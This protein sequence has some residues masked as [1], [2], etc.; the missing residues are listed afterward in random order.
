MAALYREF[1]TQSEIDAQYDIDVAVPDHAVY[2][3][4]YAG[5]SLRARRTLRC[6]LDVPYGP[7][8]EEY[9]DIFPAAV[10]GAPVFMF[11]HGGYWRG[12]SAKEFSCVALGAHDLGITTVVVNYA[13]TPK[14]SL[15][16][17][18]RQA[19][20][21]VAWVLRNIERHGADPGRVA[22]GGHSAGA[23]LAAMCLE[24][25]WQEDYGLPADPL[26][27]AVLV[28]GIYDLN[29]LR[30]SLLQPQIQ[31]DDGVIRRNS[32]LFRIRPC[33]TPAWVTW[34]GR[35]SAEF[36]RQSDTYLAAWRA[37]G[38]RGERCPQEACNHLDAIYGFEDASSELCG[39]M[40]AAVQG[41]AP[42]HLD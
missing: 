15:D 21:S 11:I 10:R 6:Q 32:P 24:T 29:P 9:L 7:T 5:T 38:N 40:A 35:E 19:R 18:T 31:L 36:H 39:W 12:L 42:G 25:A 34:G 13:L 16:E 33:A 28:S 20:A 41:N 26:T 22:I 27:G 4:H 37:A 2:S 14:V 17:I 30:F 1:C 8:R 3:R 23:H